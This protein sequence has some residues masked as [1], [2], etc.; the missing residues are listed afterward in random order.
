MGYI[1]RYQPKDANDAIYY[2]G[3]KDSYQILNLDTIHP[4][5]LQYGGKMVHFNEPIT[6]QSG[7]EIAI[8]LFWKWVEIDRESDRLDTLIGNQAALSAYD[9][10]I[11]DKYNL[12]VGVHYKL[13]LTCTE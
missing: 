4:D 11:N 5:N 6:L 7:E 13:N 9:E 12:F 8:S 10:T 3:A 1:L 2:Y